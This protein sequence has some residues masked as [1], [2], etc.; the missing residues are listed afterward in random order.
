MPEWLPQVIAASA[1]T[2]GLGLSVAGLG[3]LV[4]CAFNRY[5][6]RIQVS[7][8]THTKQWPDGSIR[9]GITNHGNTPIVVDA[10][11]VH[12]P[13]GDLFPEVANR[14]D[15]SESP[16]PPRFGGIRRFIGRLQDRLCFWKRMTRQND[17]SRLLALSMLGKAPWRHELLD[18]GVTQ[19]IE[20]K[21]SAVCSF[22]R[23]STVQQTLIDADIQTLTI[24]PSCHIVGHRRRIWGLPSI[25]ADGP[26]RMAIQFNPPRIDIKD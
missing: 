19:R 12:M 16:R 5:N 21:E 22:P 8:T 1:I 13:E 11:T 6:R 26:V 20:P 9:I 14:M 7:L 25:I 23:H 3:L 4:R 17:L 18:P 10:W 24:I 15:K 2:T